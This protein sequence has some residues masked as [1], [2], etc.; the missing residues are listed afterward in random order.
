[1]QIMGKAKSDTDTDIFTNS[2]QIFDTVYLMWEQ[3]LT[4]CGE[5]TFL[6]FVIKNKI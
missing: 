1:M 4:D 3:S 2:V 6:G 5:I